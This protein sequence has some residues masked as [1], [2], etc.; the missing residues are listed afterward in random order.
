MIDWNRVDELRAEV[1]DADFEEIGGLFLSEI[2][3][4]VGALP[5]LATEALPDALH[6][7]KGAAMNLGFA[8]LAALCVAG[9]IAPASAPVA[10]IARA[11]ETGAAEFRARFPAFA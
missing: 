5:A 7:L 1:G 6:G 9:E 11:W 3:E 10:A 2:G 4:I 8:E